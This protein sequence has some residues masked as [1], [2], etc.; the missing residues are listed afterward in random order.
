MSKSKVEIKNLPCDVL[1]CIIKYINPCKFCRCY[2]NNIRGDILTKNIY[3]NRFG[4]LHDFILTNKILLL[5][6]APIINKMRREYYLS[7]CFQELYS[8]WTYYKICE[9]ESKTLKKMVDKLMNN[10]IINPDA[11]W[12]KKYDL[13]S[14]DHFIRSIQWGQSYR[15]DDKW[16]DIL[17][18]NHINTELSIWKDDDEIK[19]V[20]YFNQEFREIW[21]RPSYSPDFTN[22]DQL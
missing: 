10:Q 3:V 15:L 14:L 11:E 2:T 19:M 7:C 1:E 5:Q 18:P 13:R 17:A 12:V 4:G 22:G 6:M 21:F 8:N 16:L 9:R 20:D